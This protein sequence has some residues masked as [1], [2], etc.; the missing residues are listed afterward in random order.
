MDRAQIKKE[1]SKCRLVH[2]LRKAGSQ[3]KGAQCPQFVSTS[4]YNGISD[5]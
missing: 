4:L 5:K 2:E 3:L 1:N